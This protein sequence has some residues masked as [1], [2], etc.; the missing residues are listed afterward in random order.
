MAKKASFQWRR[1]PM[2]LIGHL[3]N[4]TKDRTLELSKKIF[5]GIV[6]RTPVETG[7]LRASWRASLNQPDM[8]KTTGG[9]AEA[10]LAPPI[11]PLSQI[12]L[13]A[14]VFISNGQKYVMPIEYGWSQKA[15]QGMVRVTL[16][17]LGIGLR[18]RS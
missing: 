6:S 10:P 13:Y 9:T 1:D 5:D 8:S 18:I 2:R 12:P 16:A 4:V 15:P 11:F 3:E 7:S 17:S 14:K